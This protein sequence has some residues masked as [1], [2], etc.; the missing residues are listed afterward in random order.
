MPR[1]SEFFGIIIYIYFDDVGQHHT[2]HIHA[3][4]GEYVAVYSIEDGR[5]L[6]GRMKEKQTRRVRRWIEKRR[7]ELE[8][9]GQHAVNGE[10]MQWIDPSIKS[11]RWIPAT[12]S[13]A[14][15]RLARRW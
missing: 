10:K 3:R 11:L 2:P 12:L 4:Y 7:A 8:A 6:A 5:I 15:C 9:N 1:I 14:L 13:M